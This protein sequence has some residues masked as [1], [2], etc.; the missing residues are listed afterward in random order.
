MLLRNATSNSNNPTNNAPYCDNE[1][2]NVRDKGTFVDLLSL[3]MRVIDPVNSA[4]FDGL[5]GE[6]AAISKTIKWR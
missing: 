4:Y 2:G 6:A 3:L 1:D 5:Q